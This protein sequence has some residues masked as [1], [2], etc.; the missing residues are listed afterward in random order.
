[1]HNCAQ[2]LL[3][4]DMK[5]K[6]SD[7]SRARVKMLKAD[8]ALKYQC[9]QNRWFHHNISDIFAVFES[10]V[11]CDFRNKCVLSI[12]LKEFKELAVLICDGKLFQWSNVAF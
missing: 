1:M 2:I 8:V 4:S 7:S 11:G 9:Y 5:P 3:N 12:D 6:R 10:L